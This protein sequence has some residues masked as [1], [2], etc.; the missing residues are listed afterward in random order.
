MT[1]LT[2]D[3]NAPV[4]TV[5]IDRP[6]A[7]AI[8]SETSRGLGE[9]FVEF[10]DDQKMRVAIITGAGDR[11]FSAG[12]DLKAAAKGEEYEAD[13]GIGGFGGFPEL[14]NLNK[15]V[16]AAVNGS[17]VGGGFE[18]VLA[19]DLVVSAEHAEFFFGE[20]AAGVI[21]DAGTVRLPRVVSPAL[22][23]EL[24]LT[25]RRLSATEAKILGL[26]NRVVGGN[27]LMASAA[28]LAEE[29]C[30]GAPLAVEAVLSVMRQTSQMSVQQALDAMREGRVAEYSA[31]LESD[32]AKEGPRAFAQGRD[33]VWRGS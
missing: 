29:I 24:I 18:L 7:N 26:I 19:A 3:R 17:A 11:F 25:G 2:V 31:M 8:D 33:P 30:R 16:I 27:D 14:P 5:T 23:K 13:Y 22:A 15:P 10:R 4:F 20:L 32:D 1:D 9:A 28:D 12:W 21:P 6:K